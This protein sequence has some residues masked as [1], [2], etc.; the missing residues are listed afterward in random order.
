LEEAWQELPMPRLEPLSVEAG[1]ELVTQGQAAADFF[2]ILAGR[3]SV[4]ERGEDGAERRVNRL[5]EGQSFGEVALLKG[6]PRTASVR[7]DTEMRVL[8]LGRRTFIDLISDSDLL[9]S[10]LGHVV[11]QRF[12][13]AALATALPRLKP[14][15]VAGAAPEAQVRHLEGGEVVFRQGDAAGG[16]YIV[17]AGHVDVLHQ[18]EAGVETA[19]N[20]LGPGEA[21][22]EIGIL[23]RR[24]RT[25]TVRAAPGELVELLR[26]DR[27]RLEELIA[28][29]PAAQG[30]LA[31]LMS[32]R[33][34]NEIERR[35]LS[36]PGPS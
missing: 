36:G 20:R 35:G 7:A 17:L 11:Q 12:V 27:R 9:G 33:L 10:E 13:R 26:V 28:D 23:Q 31:L 4:W 1:A 19:L 21:F 3:A 5:A 14:A 18:A 29:S 16:L 34:M 24:P 6:V 30:D 2:I 25:A 15:Q 32:R 8:R 22:G